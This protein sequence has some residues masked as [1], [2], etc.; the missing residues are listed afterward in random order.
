MTVG[1]RSFNQES[2]LML[3]MNSKSVGGFSKFNYTNK[4]G[5]GKFDVIVV[6]KP[7]LKTPVNIWRLFLLGVPSF[8]DND[9]FMVFSTDK[10]TVEIVDNH[11]E[12]IEWNVD[13]DPFIAD[14]VEIQC[15][16]K[17]LNLF[18]PK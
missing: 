13:G 15:L 16:K 9:N 4:L 1:K 5:D 3:I 7:Q 8:M 11:N 6:K 17:R 18:V 14:K 12:M 2:L 10:V